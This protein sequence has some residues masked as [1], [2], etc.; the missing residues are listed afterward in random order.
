M[1]RIR[2]GT[3]CWTCRVRKKKCDEV[4][5]ACRACTSRQLQCHGY[6]P[7]PEWMDGGAREETE[8]E[9][10]KLVVKQSY[11]FRRAANAKSTR[12]LAKCFPILNPLGI[13]E[14]T[15][16]I[17]SDTIIRQHTDSSRTSPTPRD[18]L[19]DITVSR[20]MDVGYDQ[21]LANIIYFVDNVFFDQHHFYRRHPL[22]PDQIRSW[23]LNINLEMPHFLLSSL[24][25]SGVHQAVSRN[26]IHSRR[27]KP[28]IEECEGL[29][30][31]TISSL[32]DEMKQLSIITD[33]ETFHKAIGMLATTLQLFSIE[34]FR[35]N[36]LWPG[37]MGNWQVHLDGAAA[38]LS[39]IDRSP[40]AKELT[41]AP[42]NL[43]SMTSNLSVYHLDT[44]ALNFSRSIH[45]YADIIY[46]ATRGWHHPLDAEV[47]YKTYLQNESI[48]LA[49]LMGCRNTMMMSLGEISRL[50][51]IKQ[52]KQQLPSKSRAVYMDL[53]P[54]VVNVEK[55]LL[56]ESETE[57][58]IRHEKDPMPY[59]RQCSR[60]T[61][62]FALSGLIYLYVIT[63]N[64]QPGYP[65]IHRLVERAIEAIRILPVTRLKS[66]PW[67]FCV[68]GCMASDSQKQFFEDVV[69]TGL[70]SGVYLGT[71]VNALDIAQKWWE[72]RDR[73]DFV[74]DKGDV[75][76]RRVMKEFKR[77]DVLT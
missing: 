38:L 45:A 22:I 31:L 77:N 28:S 64:A 36:K 11:S 62:V 41:K 4:H 74:H 53:F 20:P 46:C 42:S 14:P 15:G 56:K 67:A 35:S 65:T 39:L 47:P 30:S 34:I 68:A 29:H 57:C 32:R 63:W 27:N 6:G 9:R 51:A 1:P 52:E 19:L 24:A 18:N 43:S 44:K 17:G 70:K 72:M 16:V 8:T 40:I 23:L 69:E 61:Q 76:W 75:P 71:I 5:P 60:V 10:I 66:I 55:A 3:G 21:E 58:N 48:D 7:R 33:T 49:S 26:S 25:I 54:R 37:E 2:S 13:P 59:A 73:D 12:G 50:E